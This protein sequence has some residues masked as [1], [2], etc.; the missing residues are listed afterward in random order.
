MA[1]IVI[2]KTNFVKTDVLLAYLRAWEWECEWEWECLFKN[3]TL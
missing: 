3:H 2:N 1:F